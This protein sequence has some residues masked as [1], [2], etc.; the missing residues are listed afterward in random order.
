MKRWPLAALLGT[1]L[2][3]CGSTPRSIESRVAAQRLNDAPERYIVAAVDNDGFTPEGHAGSTPRG[4]D[5]LT[6]YGPTSRA[7]RL[8]QAIEH[9][10][11]L[12]EIA[13]WPIAPLHMH[14]AVLEI[15]GTANRESVL[16][17]LAHDVRIRLAEPLQTFVTH[18]EGFEDRFIAPQL[19]G[20]RS[21][22]AKAAP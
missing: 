14:C 18:A 19:T 9:D 8:M 10:Y 11:G 4:Y 21:G 5:G 17:A 20:F 2:C 7:L 1:A 16:A 6:V 12:R 13:A 22:F 15:P 3:A